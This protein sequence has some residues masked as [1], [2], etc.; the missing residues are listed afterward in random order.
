M[1]IECGAE[2]ERDAHFCNVCRKE[3]LVPFEP[4]PEPAPPRPRLGEDR[5]AVILAAVTWFAGIG[6]LVGEIAPRAWTTLF[7]GWAFLAVV[8]GIVGMIVK[9][10]RVFA[11][12]SGLGLLCCVIYVL[13]RST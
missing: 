10:V 1:C 5:Y 3:S 11:F 12:F 7:G 4:P 2:Y 6:Y 8:S 9:N 13:V